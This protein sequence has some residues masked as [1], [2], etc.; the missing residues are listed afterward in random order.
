MKKKNI[1]TLFVI[2]Y[3]ALL[4]LEPVVVYGGIASKIRDGVNAF[5]EQDLNININEGLRPITEGINVKDR[6]EKMP[7]VSIRFSTPNPKPGEPVT[8]FADVYG[9]SNI[10]NAYYTWYLKRDGGGTMQDMKLAAIHAAAEL[11]FNPLTFDQPMNG[12]DG[13]GVVEDAEWPTTDTDND[14]YRAKMGGDTGIDRDSGD[15]NDYC[16]IYD[17]ESGIQYELEPK[18]FDVKSGD[19]GCP[20]G[21]EPR[22]MVEHNTMQCPVLIDSVATQEEAE[23]TGGLS[24]TT[25]TVSE[26]GGMRFTT[27]KQC[28]ESGVPTCDEGS[29]RLYCED[30]TGSNMYDANKYYSCKDG[31]C[32]DYDSLKDCQK[33][34]SDKTCK[35]GDALSAV[36]YDYGGSINIPT[37]FCVKKDETTNQLW[38]DPNIEGC[39][40]PGSGSGAGCLD[41]G[42]NLLVPGSCKIKSSK[43]KGCGSERHAFLKGVGDGSFT[44]DEERFFNLNPYTDRT[45]PFAKNDEAFVAGLGLKELTWKYQ[46]GDE[47]GVIV[48][49]RGYT[50]TKHEDAT[51]QTVF[52]LLKPACKDELDDKTEY[53][54]TAKGKV[55]KIKTAD[56]DLDKCVLKNNLF[57]KPGTLEHDALDVTLAIEGVSKELS[58]QSAVPSG[59]GI[60]KT[61]TASAGRVQEGTVS[62]P[63]SLYYE[64]NIKCAPGIEGGEFGSVGE[65]FINENILS[66]TKGINLKDLVM[67]MNFPDKCFRN[68]QG[69]VKVTAKINEPRTGGGSNFGKSSEI[70]NIYNIKENP[71]DVYETKI[72]NGKY[73][74]TTKPIC[75]EG[76]DK[77]VCRVMNNEVVAIKAEEF[78][79][80][81][82]SNESNTNTI[83]LPFTGDDGDLIPVTA[84]MSNVTYD[85]NQKQQVTRVFRITE[86]SVMIVP[87]DDTVKRK[88]IAQQIFQRYCIPNFLI[89]RNMMLHMS[90][91]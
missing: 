46:E 58:T 45:T 49:G 68:G 1:L 16:Y 23:Q 71:L 53:E 19:N 65:D 33:H 8:A 5:I 67:I 30:S 76:I 55:I 43:N 34:E 87:Q 15:G 63:S 84:N 39:P 81:T 10:N 11:Y 17:P 47:I 77:T 64:W 41:H 70:F 91:M 90:G 13:D 73:K 51:Y 69:R 18:D 83:I 82:C 31:L 24:H 89:Q 21:Y 54:E 59:L 26:G 88:I 38:F 57:V 85:T 78:T 60:E 61:I 79:D 80:G 12:G 48:E 86:P 9:V 50:A 35:K 74:M 75:N 37:P 4:T 27:V 20:S 28:L 62:Q 14:G 52:A 3:I 40:P 6:K 22:C 32:K 44:A 25:G 66:K 56:V 36:N 72:E 2:F 42:S 29:Q 7:E